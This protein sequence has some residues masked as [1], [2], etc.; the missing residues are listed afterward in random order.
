VPDGEGNIDKPAHFNLRIFFRV[1]GSKWPRK[2]DF[3]DTIAIHAFGFHVL[4]LLHLECAK[5]LAFMSTPLASLFLQNQILTGP[6]STCAIGWPWAKW[7]FLS[8]TMNSTAAESS[9]S[10]VGSAYSK[11]MATLVP[12]CKARTLRSLTVASRIRFGQWT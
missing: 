2:D 11:R 6:P 12:S 1:S 8:P 3:P 7:A 10:S 5:P 4:V 9:A